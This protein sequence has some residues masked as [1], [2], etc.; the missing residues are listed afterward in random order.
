VRHII[1]RIVEAWFEL[2][3]ETY[4]TPIALAL[5]IFYRAISCS[6]ILH[7]S[8]YWYLASPDFLECFVLGCKI[9]VAGTNNSGVI[10]PVLNPRTLFP[11]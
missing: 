2:I 7:G 1:S 3:G 5:K 6:S 9:L 10:F 11:Q 8:A 4:L